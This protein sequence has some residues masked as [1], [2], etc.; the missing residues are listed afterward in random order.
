MQG[1]VDGD[2]LN[3]LTSPR[4]V[5]TEPV[6]EAAQLHHQAFDND[7]VVRIRL[8]AHPITGWLSKVALSFKVRL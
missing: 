1:H 2:L 3:N 6:C 7:F 8:V 4:F 5:Q